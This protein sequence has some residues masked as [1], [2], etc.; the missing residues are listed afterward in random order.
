MDTTKL[1]LD[2]ERWASGCCKPHP[3]LAAEL[4]ASLTPWPAQPPASPDAG[5]P[6][7]LLHPVLACAAGCLLPLQGAAHH[8]MLHLLCIWGWLTGVVQFMAISCT[9][10]MEWCLPFAKPSPVPRPPQQLS[11]HAQPG[12]RSCFLPA[13]PPS[14]IAS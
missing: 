14:D 10:Q 6:S 8:L 11:L 12:S 3:V 1:G 5:L 7:W 9:G 2:A 4:P 13:L